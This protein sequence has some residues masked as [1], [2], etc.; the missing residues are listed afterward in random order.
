MSVVAASFPGGLRLH[1]P[2]LDLLRRDA[3]PSTAGTPWRQPSSSLFFCC[4][5]DA[6]AV[7]PSRSASSS[8]G[9]A[10]STSPG[11]LLPDASLLCADT[12]PEVIDPQSS[13]LL[14]GDDVRVSYRSW[15]S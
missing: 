2:A 9:Y 3:A 11:L 6:E 7:L 8:A 15:C 10:S 12:D 5:G 1:S 4:C 13:L 14:D